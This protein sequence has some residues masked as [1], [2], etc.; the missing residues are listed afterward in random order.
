MTNF[1]V[2]PASADVFSDSFGNNL[3]QISNVTG[4]QDVSAGHLPVYIGILL[5]WGA[6]L[7]VTIVIQAVL[8]AYEY[9]TAQ[10]DSDKVS[11]ARKR[12]RNVV[13]SGVILAGG[14]IIAA[15]VIALWSK[16]TGYQG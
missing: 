14:Y 11:N 13:I 9:M 3:S 1:F 12:I 10:G 2:L 6:F 4:Y 5:G 15:V 16:Y 7:G 8:A